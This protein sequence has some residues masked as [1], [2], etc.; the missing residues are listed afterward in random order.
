MPITEAHEPSL[1]YEKLRRHTRMGSEQSLKRLGLNS[2]K[3][4]RLL[5]KS[6][7]WGANC[8]GRIPSLS[9]EP[10]FGHLR[11]LLKT[12]RGNVSITS[13]NQAIHL[14]TTSPS[15]RDD[16]PLP[17]GRRALHLG[18]TSHSPRGN[19]PVASG[20][21]GELVTRASSSTD[22]A[23]SSRNTRATSFRVPE[24][25]ISGYPNKSSRVPEPIA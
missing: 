7:S 22:R 24:A 23:G 10:D 3:A 16:E 8:W 25:I 20:S 15:P 14:G 6:T 4:H 17:S 13:V 1:K 11:E 2:R 12:P 21:I 5:L 19:M 9:T 18:T